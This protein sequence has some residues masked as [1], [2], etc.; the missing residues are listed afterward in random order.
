MLSLDLESIICRRKVLFNVR[1]A[2]NV[3]HIIGDTVHGHIRSSLL[4]RR[5][6]HG[7][8]SEVIHK[9]LS[10]VFPFAK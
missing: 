8:D 4:G 9:T 2:R 6:Y 1:L 3:A 7:S 10:T 5:R